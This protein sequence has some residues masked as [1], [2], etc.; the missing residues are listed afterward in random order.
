[1]RK[2]KR[3]REPASAAWLACA[4]LGM[5]LPLAGCSRA[6]TFNILGSYFPAWLVCIVAGIA[7][8][9]TGNRLLARFK[10]DEHI[11]W[12]IVVYPCL[13]LFFACTIWLIFFS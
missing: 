9:A 8:A 3:I 12:A 4:G 6:P 5:A 1:M 11:P 10:F 7:L 13:A 2:T